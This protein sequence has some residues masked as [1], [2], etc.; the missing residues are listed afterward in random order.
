MAT[1]DCILAATVYL[2][3]TMSLG[4]NELEQLGDVLETVLLVCRE[5]LERNDRCWGGRFEQLVEQV[6]YSEGLLTTKDNVSLRTH[7]CAFFSLAGDR[8]RNHHLLD[9][10][11][12]LNPA[13]IWFETSQE[14]LSWDSSDDPERGHGVK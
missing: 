3:N 13:C 4:N 14:A 10:H 5:A 11:Q 8:Q 9:E 12:I 1:Q 7:L 2:E 6:L